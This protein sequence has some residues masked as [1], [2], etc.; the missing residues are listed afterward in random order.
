MA[1][2]TGEAAL[3]VLAAGAAIALV[4][5]GLSVF[6]PALGVALGL[7]WSVGSTGTAVGISAAPG[8][9]SAATY[10]L[11]L[12][13][14]GSAI[15]VAVNIAERAQRE[16]FQWLL[17]VLAVVNGFL[18]Q[19]CSEYWHGPKLVWLILSTISALLVVIGGALYVQ[20][21]VVLKG[22]GFLLHLLIPLIVLLSIT[23]ASAS[24]IEAAILEV[25]VRAWLLL[26]AM[27]LVAVTLAALAKLLQRE[28]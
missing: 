16:P 18:V 13:G 12:A 6:L 28:Q 11:F 25:P 1:N 19:I 17:P 15:Y 20:G 24:T 22:L 5:W 10:G 9:V 23:S 27:V 14:G 26:T 2:N 4:L 3:F 8:L 7:A 21:S